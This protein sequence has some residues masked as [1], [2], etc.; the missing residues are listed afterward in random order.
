MCKGDTDWMKACIKLVVEKT[1][2]VSTG[3]GD[4]HKLGVDCQ[5]R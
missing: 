1:A 5:H 3:D 4:M 2:S